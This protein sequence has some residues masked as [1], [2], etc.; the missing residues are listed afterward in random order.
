MLDVH[1][2][3]VLSQMCDHEISSEDDFEWLSQLRYYWEEENMVTRMINSMLKYGYEY[4]GMLIHAPFS[5]LYYS[6]YYFTYTPMLC[7]RYLT[8]A[9]WQFLTYTFIL[10]RI[11]YNCFAHGRN[12]NLPYRCQNPLTPIMPDMPSIHITQ[13]RYM[14][15][16]ILS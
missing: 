11:L 1:G 6:V 4:L 13:H 5:H 14:L 12:I 15:T 3:D 2:R 7:Y 10:H 8:L 9:Y 16:L